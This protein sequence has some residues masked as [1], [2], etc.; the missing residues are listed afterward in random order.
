LYDDQNKIEGNF[1]ID[2]QRLA[3]M[4][5]QR[6]IKNF[7]GD[8]TKVTLGGQSAGASSTCVHLVSGKSNNLFQKAIIESNPITIPWKLKHSARATAQIFYKHLSCSDIE[9]LR[10]ASVDKLLEA[11]IEAGRNVNMTEFLYTFM[12]WSPVIDGVDIKSDF[13]SLVE[14]G[15]FKKMPL[16]FGTTADES[17]IFI[18]RGFQDK[19]NDARYVG[20]LYAIFGRHAVSVVRQYPPFPIGGD[21]R[22]VLDRLANDFVFFGVNRYLMSQANKHNKDGV[23]YWYFNRPMAFDGW[24]P[25]FS[26]CKDLACHGVNIG[27]LFQTIPEFT[28]DEQKTSLEM[29]RYYA[30]F[31]HSGNPNEG[32]SKP[33][34]TWPKF[35]METKEHIQFDKTQVVVG[36][37][38]HDAKCNYW[39][40]MGYNF[41]SPL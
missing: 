22:L 18:R 5:V 15:D 21:K 27:F 41:G 7:G 14:K 37:N 39:D 9:C 11:Q 24:G 6:N 13:I 28:P 8:S 12:P 3:L 36:K 20:L 29:I 40:G 38:L 25:I 17:I 35:N 2:D 31:I 4:F 34:V 10:S 19:L 33:A 30:N 16:M 26:F 1:G 23:Y 32:V